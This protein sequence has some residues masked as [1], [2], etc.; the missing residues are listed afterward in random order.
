M[1][2]CDIFDFHR[3]VAGIPGHA[4]SHSLAADESDEHIAV[5]EITVYHV[6]LLVT[7]EQQVEITAL[8]R[9]DSLNIHY[10]LT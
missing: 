9:G 7:D 4:H 6:R 10:S 1:P 3:S 2:Y 5:V 8:M